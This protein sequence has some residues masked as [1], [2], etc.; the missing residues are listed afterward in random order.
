MAN[1]KEKS[2]GEGII[3]LANVLQVVLSIL[4]VIG[5][6]IL[7]AAGL[8][9]NK[10]V[11]EV[12]TTVTTAA[13][14]NIPGFISGFSMIVCGVLVIVVGLILVAIYAMFIRCYGEIAVDLHCIRNSNATLA[15][16]VDNANIARRNKE[17]Q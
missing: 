3:K 7:I 15:E 12:G 14:Y 6:G 4:C 13:A 8:Y 1:R 17:Q 9:V 10:G 5:G 16:F 11:Y 2:S